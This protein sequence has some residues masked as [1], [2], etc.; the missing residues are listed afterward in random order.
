GAE[1]TPGIVLGELHQGREKAVLRGVIS[2]IRITQNRPCYTARL[3]RIAFH[4]LPECGAVAGQSL[5][6][7]P[8]VVGFA[9]HTLCPTRRLGGGGWVGGRCPR[10][11]AHR[12]RGGVADVRRQSPQAKGMW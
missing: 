10:L 12:S 5:G 6:D 7:K 9:S 3:S 4:Q 2:I 8:P 1:R 11:S